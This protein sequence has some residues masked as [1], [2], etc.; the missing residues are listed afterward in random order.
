M[1]VLSRVPGDVF[2]D[3][4]KFD[5]FVNK[6]CI[7]INKAVPKPGN[8]R[9]SHFQLKPKDLVVIRS[10]PFLEIEETPL[11]K[12]NRTLRESLIIL[13]YMQFF[14]KLKFPERIFSAD[15]KNLFNF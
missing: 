8:K 14:E 4:S 9:D 10:D 13:D 6:N 12:S 15:D 5:E 11:I 2:L 3:K 7:N 1:P